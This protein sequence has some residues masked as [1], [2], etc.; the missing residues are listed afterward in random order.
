M[1][2]KSQIGRLCEYLVKEIVE[3][4]TGF[5]VTNAN[6]EATNYP[7]IDLVVFDS[8]TGNEYTIS[9]KAKTGSMWPSVKGIQKKGQYII[10][11]SVE[12]SADPCFYILTKR[13]WDSALRRMLPNR[14]AGATIVNGAIEWNWKVRGKN[15]KRRGS[16]VLPEDIKRHKNK[17]HALPGVIGTA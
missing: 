11:V 13:Q 17:W 10:F 1:T 15:Q 6:D 9:V 12:A 16:F 4:K 3:R 7:V 2:S 8:A 14:Q 5:T